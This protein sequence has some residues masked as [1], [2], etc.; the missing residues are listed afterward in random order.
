MFGSI[1]FLFFL[2]YNIV[3]MAMRLLGYLHHSFHYLRKPV[4]M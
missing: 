4:V 2:Y 3:Y 1:N